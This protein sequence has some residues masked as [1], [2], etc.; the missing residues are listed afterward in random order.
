MRKKPSPWELLVCTNKLT[1]VQYVRITKGS[2]SSVVDHRKPQEH[3]SL[4]KKDRWKKSSGT[5]ARQEVTS[6]LTLYDSHFSVCHS[7]AATFRFHSVAV[8][9]FYF[10]LLL[11]ASPSPFIVL[12]YSDFTRS[13]CHAVALWRCKFSLPVSRLCLCSCICRDC[14]TKL[15]H[16]KPGR[17]RNLTGLTL[18]ATAVHFHAEKMEKSTEEISE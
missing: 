11:L 6:G 18:H 7:N 15:A 16:A 13:P 12:S 8:S 2:N 5:A 9:R 4:F 17:E 3:F 1:S 10:P 14:I